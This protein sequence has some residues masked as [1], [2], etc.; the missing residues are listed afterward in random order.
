LVPCGGVQFLK[1]NFPPPHNSN[2]C[3]TSSKTDLKFPTVYQRAKQPN[4]R[5]N[6]E[7]FITKLKN[8]QN[9][10]NATCLIRVWFPQKCIAFQEPIQQKFSGKKK[11]NSW[12]I[13]IIYLFLY[14][15]ENLQNPIFWDFSVWFAIA[16]RLFRVE[17]PWN[18]FFLLRDL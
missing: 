18:V 6:D 12:K 17:F 2:F 13:L 4:N 16:W 14:F 15:K 5:P 7:R 8:I 11:E 3:H 9:E 10:E 1:L